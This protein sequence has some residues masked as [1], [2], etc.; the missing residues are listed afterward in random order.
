M[1]GYSYWGMKVW[2]RGGRRVSC[3]WTTCVE[4][5]DFLPPKTQSLAS[6]SFWVPIT[7]QLSISVVYLDAI[8]SSSCDDFSNKEDC[9]WRDAATVSR[10]YPPFGIYQSDCLDMG[11][12]AN[13]DLKIC[14]VAK[15]AWIIFSHVV[16]KSFHLPGIFRPALSARCL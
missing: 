5:V 11:D 10:Q 8:K 7:L 16:L 13:S 12:D 4:S 9:P 14:C 2:D 3:C 1:G 6:G 15:K